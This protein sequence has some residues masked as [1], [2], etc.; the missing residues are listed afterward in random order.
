MTL[1]EFLVPSDEE[2]LDAL[3]V[4]PEPV[5]GEIAVR[6]VRCTTDAGDLLDLI[7]DLP[8]NSIRCRWQRGE[9]VLVDIF[10][11]G[12][13]RLSVRSGRGEA[14]LVVSFDTEGL[15]GELAIQVLPDI[16]VDDRL[17]FA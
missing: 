6:R 3:G 13:C 7:F 4:E 12:A 2:W 10:R 8:G 5:D 11:E 15:R 14:H 1:R 17:L 16:R 9:I